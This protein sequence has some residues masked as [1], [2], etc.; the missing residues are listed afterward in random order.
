MAKS[1]ENDLLIF[2]QILRKSEAKLIRKRLALLTRK[3]EHIKLKLF[4]NIIKQKK[5]DHELFMK[6]NNLNSRRYSLLKYELLK[7]ILNYLKFNYQPYSEIALQNEIIEYQLLLKGGLFIKANRKLKIIK[8]IC[9]EKCDFNTC[10]VVQRKAIEYRLFNQSNNANT[11]SQALGELSEYHN[12]AENLN[13]YELL[14]EEV[15]N[16][17][18]ECLDKRAENRLT[19]LDFL[20][21]DLLVSKE[22]ANSIMSVYY[23]HRIKSLIYIGANDYQNCKKYS[24]IAYNYLSSNPSKYRNDYLHY[25]NSIN[26]Y[27]DSSL[28]LLE[29]KPFEEMYPKMVEMTNAHLDRT[30]VYSSAISFQLL[31]TLKLNYLWIKQDYK[32]FLLVCDDFEKSYKEYEK[33]LRPNLKLEILLGFARLYFLEGNL[34]KAN[35]FC[36]LISNERTN[37]TSLF[38]SCGNILRVM[39]NFD[40]GDHSFMPHLINTSTYFLKN[41]GRFFELERIFFKGIQKIKPYYPFSRKSELFKTLYKEINQQLLETDDMIVDRKINILNW[42]NTNSEY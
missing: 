38:I 10:C 26:N 42:L 39:I 6:A 23:Y 9:L 40:L 12:M 24:L 41:R 25:L 30:D 28:N 15:L 35:H 33:V 31:C 3:G 11:I 19:I 27:L 32:S 36:R 14:S 21:H 22:K 34:V 29:T 2:S 37:P 1:E 17:H 5:I 7:D 8:E 18:Y 20:D 4:D 13:A 16:I